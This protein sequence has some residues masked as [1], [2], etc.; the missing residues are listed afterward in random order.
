MWKCHNPD[1]EKYFSSLLCEKNGSSC[2]ECCLP[3]PG[4]Q[5]LTS[6]AL[7]LETVSEFFMDSENMFAQHTYYPLDIVMLG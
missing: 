7:I 2:S 1:H 3:S 4:P 5:T 6:K